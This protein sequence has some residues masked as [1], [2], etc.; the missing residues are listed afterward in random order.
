VCVC[1]CV[2][3]CVRSTS[4]ETTGEMSTKN[5]SPDR[6]RTACGVA[7]GSTIARGAHT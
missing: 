3:V 6:G 7:V 4:G 5:D 1:V 2:C